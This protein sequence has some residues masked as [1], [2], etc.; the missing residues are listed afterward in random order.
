MGRKAKFST[1]VKIKACQ[2]YEKGYDS[3]ATFT[4]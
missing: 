3:F 2:D 1:E 4:K